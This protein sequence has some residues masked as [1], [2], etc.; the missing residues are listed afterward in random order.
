V[1]YPKSHKPGKPNTERH[2]Q[3]N[4]SVLRLEVW[5]T[6]D[7]YAKA[8][9]IEVQLRYNGE[10]NGE[11]SYSVREAQEAGV[12]SKNTAARAFKELCRRGFLRP[13]RRSN[14]N[15]KTLASGHGINRVGSRAQEWWITY[16]P[17]PSSAGRRQPP[18]RDYLNWRPTPIQNAVPDLG[19]RRTNGRDN[20]GCQSQEMSIPVPFSVTEVS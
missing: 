2:I 17:G 10:N 18:T 20:A 9:L 4:H 3:L 19:T 6:M 5:K 11:I 8:L 15:L 14:F 16:L 12:M 7:A 13:G 1:R